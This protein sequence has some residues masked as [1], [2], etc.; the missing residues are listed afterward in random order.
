MSVAEVFYRL[1]QW[2]VTRSGR[3]QFGA[4]VAPEPVRRQ[5]PDVGVRDAPMGVAAASYL[6]EADAIL[7]GNVILFANRRFNL[8]PPVNWN[9]D[10][11]TGVVGPS[12]YGPQIAILDKQL[13]G[14]IKHV[15]ELNRHLHLVRLAQAFV[16]SRER[17]YLD[18]LGAQL[19]SWL[20][21]C[22]P[23]TGPNW[24][25]SL[26]LGIRLINW[27]LI[28]EMLGGWDGPL[29]QGEDGTRL[30]SRWLE[31]VWAH[32]QF[33]S[34]HFSRHSSANNHLIG[35][36]AG[37]YVS[38]ITW[39]CWDEAANWR[40]NAKS[41]LER[42]ALIQ[43]TVDGVNREHAFAY[44]VF[45]AEFLLVAGTRGAQVG[46]NF[47]QEYWGVLRKSSFFLRAVMNVN[48]HLPAVG[49]ADDGMVYRLTP[50]AASDRV[51]GFLA[52]SDVL[53]GRSQKRNRP[54][55]ASWLL[56]EVDLKVPEEGKDDSPG[57]LFPE[58]GY[59]VFGCRFGEPDEIKGLVDCA[60]I[61]Y[62]GI[63]AH[64][65]A[66]ALAMVLSVA[67]EP[68]LVDSGTFSYWNESRW[69][70]YF[71]GTSAHNTVRVDGKDQSVS[72]GPFMWTRKA[73]S[74]VDVLPRSADPFL[75]VASHDGYGR[76]ADPVRHHRRIEFDG[77]SGNLTVSDEII[78]RGAHEVEQFW[79]F[80][81]DVDVVLAG[82]TATA[83]GTRFSIQIEFSGA[84]AK[85]FLVRG[86][87][88]PPLGW[89]SRN[90]E[91]KEPTSV[92]VVRA[93]GVDVALSAK[94]K[95]VVHPTLKL[96][97]H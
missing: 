39:P 97:S 80:A 89:V 70:D 3:R 63:A 30:R 45:T 52:V 37:L 57:W 76:L 58:G 38:C 78:G 24:S 43:H 61:G 72:G 67:G 54:E 77:T 71:R 33:V 41:E 17:R 91:S 87:D 32:C 88:N 74:R 92:L 11:L 46:D 21:Q 7:D 15:W 83:S 10:P 34:R 25:S 64:G 26:E 29:F 22:P 28:W 55:V 75:L 93:S 35:E 18:G 51:G 56:P 73:T 1:Q 85:V 60:P 95:V 49:D 68:C 96:W 23:L 84:G 6:E 14:D 20:T 16:L 65:H 27:S 94:F 4:T 69:R 90:Y 44:Q 12:S 19:R 82:A 79:H 8:P 48:G 59:L 53:F 86:A 81:P 62:L 9:C 13:V 47:S 5:H 50:G 36:L 42:E 2:R 40:L 66:D 31:S